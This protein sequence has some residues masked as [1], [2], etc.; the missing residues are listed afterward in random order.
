MHLIAMSGF[1]IG[2][3]LEALEIVF[4]SIK[5]PKIIRR[6]TA[7]VLTFIYIW[8]VGMPVGCIEGFCNGELSTVSFL[9][10]KK[11]SAL[12]SLK[13]SALIILALNPYNIVSSSFWMSYMAVLGILLF[14]KRYDYI[15]KRNF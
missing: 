7:I 14:Y 12:S 6:V 4:K 10:K 2:I 15:F 11:Y 13:L 5:I 8:L 1:H 9:M 3:V